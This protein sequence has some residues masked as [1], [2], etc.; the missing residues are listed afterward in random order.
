MVDCA[1]V[2]S[3]LMT[4][5]AV[6][7][8]L[9]P[10]HMG[11]A[12]ITRNEPSVL[13]WKLTWAVTEFGVE[14]TTLRP[15]AVTAASEPNVCPDAPAPALSTQVS[16]SAATAPDALADGERPLHSLTCAVWLLLGSAPVTSTTNWAVSARTY[17]V[18]VMP[19][20]D[21]RSMPS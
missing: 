13:G 3:P 5:V 11:A 18:R 19:P 2:A 16:A 20:P 17:A 8:A 7:T 15:P 14:P 1:L 21:S 4:A 12:T 9:P 6:V 10:V